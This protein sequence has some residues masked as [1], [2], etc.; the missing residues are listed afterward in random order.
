VMINSQPRKASSGQTGLS[1]YFSSL[2]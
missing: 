2:S 1:K